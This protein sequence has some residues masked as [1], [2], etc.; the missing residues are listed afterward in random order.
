[1]A[2][3][4]RFSVEVTEKGGKKR[5]RQM[6]EAGATWVEAYDKIKRQLDRDTGLESWRFLGV[7][8]R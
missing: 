6:A 7:V 4:H 8:R 1:M 2:E 3:M 5:R